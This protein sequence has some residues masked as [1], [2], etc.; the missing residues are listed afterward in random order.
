M[1]PTGLAE[2]FET[3]PTARFRLTLSNG[4]VVDVDN[5]RRTLIELIT[6]YVGQADDPQARV[7]Q[8]TKI[9]SIPNIALV[10]KVDP[11]SPNGRRRRR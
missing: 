9:V 5:P 1:S 2:I 4:D 10:E 11:R 6:L 3:N 8:R 7:A